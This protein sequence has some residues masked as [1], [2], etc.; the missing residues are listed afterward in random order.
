MTEVSSTS[1]AER[2]AMMRSMMSHMF[3]NMDMAEKKE[4]FEAMIGKLTEGLD[5]KEMMTRTLAGKMPKSAGDG[6]GGMQEMM[7]KMMQGGPEQQPSQMPEMMLKSMMPHCIEMMLPAIA[8][9]KR[10]EAVSAILSTIVAKGAEGMS[11]AE[12]ERYRKSLGEA[13]KP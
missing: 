1:K 8:P 9:D 10:G 6:P 5:M 11:D 12:A 2:Q 4:I 3:S 13:L 7:A